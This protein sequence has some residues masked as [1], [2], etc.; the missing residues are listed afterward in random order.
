M[1][2]TVAKSNLNN[3]E[4]TLIPV[5]AKMIHSVV[6]QYKRP[7]LKDGCPLH[8]VKFVGAVKNFSVNTKNVKIDVEDGTGL[9]QGFFWRKEKECMAEHPLICK[10]N[11]N[12]YI[13]VIGEVEDYYGVYE[14]IAFDVRPVSSSNKVTHH[15]LEVVY[16]F[17]KMLE[18]AED[19]M[20]KAVP[21]K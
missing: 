20:L 17:E 5:T 18:Y 8:M 21:L 9:V 1:S 15:F 16:S 19:E 10:Y 12:G 3:G 7:I 11:R 4:H 2:T 6:S 14:I 13:C